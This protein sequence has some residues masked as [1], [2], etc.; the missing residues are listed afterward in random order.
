M[1]TR[2]PARGRSLLDVGGEHQDAGLRMLVADPQRGAQAVVG[3]GRR[4]ADVDHRDVR[5]VRPDLADEVVRVPR[6][7]HDVE[8][9][10]AEEPGDSLAQQDRVLRDDYSHGILAITVV[11]EPVPESTSSRP[12]SAD[13]RSARPRSRCRDSVGPADAIVG[14]LDDD[15]AVLAAHPDDR[16]TGVRVLRDVG[17]R[18]GDDEVGGELDRLRD[19][20]AEARGNLDRQ[21]RPRASASSAGSRPR[22]ESTAGWIPR[23]SSRSSP[24]ACSSS[25]RRRRGGAP[26]APAARARRRGQ[27][28]GRGPARR[29]AAGRRRA[30]RAPGARA[31]RARSRAGGRA[32]RAARRSSPQLSVEAL[33][34][35]RERRRRAHGLDQLGLV[36]QQWV[37]DEHRDALAVE[38][39]VGGRP[40]GAGRGRLHLPARRIDVALGLRQPVG[41][42]ERGSLSAR[43]S[44]SRSS[45]P[46]SG[47]PIRATSSVTAPPTI[48]RRAQAR[49][50]RGRGRGR[51]GSGPRRRCSPPRCPRPSAGSTSGRRSGSPSA[52][53]PRRTRA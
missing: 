40:A 48:I 17:E 26:P 7:A 9:M 23:A 2:R 14:D 10:I 29:A 31:R 20:L 45:P 44:A 1:P 24:S 34:L 8:A 5:L 22:S 41:Q 13:T 28:G 33:L 51:T 21:R 30:G 46:P 47:P 27:V 37:V 52:S 42:L 35:E 11:P 3:V 4:H 18:L 25:L 19:P 6:L 12:P 39:D 53:R 32:I 16:A 43:A 50:G 49:R 38:R 15:A 36:E